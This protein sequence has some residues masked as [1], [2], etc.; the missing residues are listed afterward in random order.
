[1]TSCAVCIYFDRN[2][3]ISE[4]RRCLSYWELASQGL[5]ALFVFPE[6]LVPNM[7]QCQQHKCVHSQLKC[8]SFFF[9]YCKFC[10]VVLQLSPSEDE[11][12]PESP[13]V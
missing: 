11:K 13:P 7:Y 5:S 3:R 10:S 1:M 4:T 6:R 12:A 8:F 2:H 9:K